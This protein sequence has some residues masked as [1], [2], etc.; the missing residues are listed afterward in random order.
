MA[1]N[2]SLYLYIKDQLNNQKLQYPWRIVL[3]ENIK[4]LIVQVLIP[5]R[6]EFKGTPLFDDAKIP[7]DQ[8]DYIEINFIY[9]LIA[10]DWLTSDLNYY[11]A[12]LDAKGDYFEQG[13][14]DITI[15]ALSK[16]IGDI[17]AQITDLSAGR[18]SK[19]FVEW[20]TALVAN[21]VK[22]RKRINRFDT[23]RLVMSKE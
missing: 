16:I 4:Q 1:I 3:D 10:E 11:I 19:M 7:V 15:Y 9:S 21:M 12:P 2:E 8:L 18:L 23:T 5:I 17:E 22:D 14:I 20:P 13:Y 6:D